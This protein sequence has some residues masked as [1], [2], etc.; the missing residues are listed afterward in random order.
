MYLARYIK[1]HI[2]DLENGRTYILLNMPDYETGQPLNTLYVHEWKDEAGEWRDL[3]HQDGGLRFWDHL[4]SMLKFD[5]LEAQNAVKDDNITNLKIFANEAR[6]DYD[7]LH[8]AAQELNLDIVTTYVVDNVIH[9]LR[10]AYTPL[11]QGESAFRFKVGNEV[12]I[13][14]PDDKNHDEVGTIDR[15]SNVENAAQPYEVRFTFIESGDDWDEVQWYRES[16]LVLYIAIG[17]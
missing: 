11:Q 17:K 13:N 8:N 6:R 3:A 2:E 4:V 1:D 12:R 16:E 7:K 10:K 15:I 14:N 5:C 9:A